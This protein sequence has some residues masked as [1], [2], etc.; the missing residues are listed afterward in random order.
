[1]V[2]SWAEFYADHDGT[3]SFWK[4][5]D[6]D[7]N[8]PVLKFDTFLADISVYVHANGPKFDLMDSLSTFIKVN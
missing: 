7:Q 4:F 5:W 1:M 2:K 6:L 3:N 8:N